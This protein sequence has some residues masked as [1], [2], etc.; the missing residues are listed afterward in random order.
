MIKNAGKMPFPAYIFV[1]NFAK[2]TVR[3]VTKEGQTLFIGA[4]NTFFKVL[5]FDRKS[6]PL[7]SGGGFSRFGPF[8]IEA[9]SGLF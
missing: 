5:P 2:I 4:C 7:C 8:A 3:R 9:L 1:K 6:P